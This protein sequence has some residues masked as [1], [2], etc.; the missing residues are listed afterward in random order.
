MTG[1]MELLNLYSVGLSTSSGRNVLTR[2]I[3]SRMSLAATSRSVPHSNSSE[4]SEKLS[5]D[6]EV[7][8]FRL[9]TVLRLSSSTRVTLV[10]ISAALAPS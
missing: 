4:M 7:I 3:A 9:S 1:I 6:L 5:D 2:S 10:S 8:S